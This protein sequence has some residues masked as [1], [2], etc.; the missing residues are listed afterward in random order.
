MT[1][2]EIYSKKKICIKYWDITFRILTL[3]IHN[4][5]EIVETSV[6]IELKV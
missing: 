6:G 3:Y 2:W 4:V 1:N 5:I